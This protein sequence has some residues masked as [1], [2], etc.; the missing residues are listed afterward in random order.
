MKLWLKRI[1]MY[2]ILGLMLIFT[3]Y[4]ATHPDL[5]IT[6]WANEGKAYVYG[7]IVII[8]VSLVI[9][10]MLMALH[11]LDQLFG[12]DEHDDVVIML[13]VLTPMALFIMIGI[14][15]KNYFSYIPVSLLGLSGYRLFF[16]IQKKKSL[17]SKTKLRL[18]LCLRLVLSV[19]VWATLVQ[20]SL[21]I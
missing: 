18:M 7:I 15:A 20:F 10:V 17:V 5:S 13:S 11:F 14:Y 9:A 1:M 2:I 3:M 6:F 21:N 16:F 12:V 4:L 19:W 8:V